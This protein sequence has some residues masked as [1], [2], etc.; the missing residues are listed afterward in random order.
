MTGK[1][2]PMPTIKK[3]A[4]EGEVP[5]GPP[6]RFLRRFAVVEITGLPTST[7]YQMMKKG[8]FPRPVHI[9]PRVVAWRSGEI[10]TWQDRCQRSVGRPEQVGK[11][12]SEKRGRA[13]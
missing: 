12:P 10:A 9:S 13:R 4:N 5:A 11:K 3:L 1:G 7:I 6:A 2:F 8:T